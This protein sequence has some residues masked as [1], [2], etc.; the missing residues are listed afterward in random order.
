MAARTRSGAGGSW[1]ARATASRWAVPDGVHR[2]QPARGDRPLGHRHAR[3]PFFVLPVP[4]PS[5]TYRGGKPRRHHHRDGL[6]GHMLI[7]LI[8][9]LD[10]E[11]SVYRKRSRCAATASTTSASPAPTS[12]P[13]AHLPGARLPR[14]VP[15]RGADRGRGGLPRQRLPG[16]SSASR[17]PAGDPGMDATF[18]RFW[19]ASRRVGRQRS[20]PPLPLITDRNDR[21][22]PAP[23]RRRAPGN[24]SAGYQNAAW[25]SCS[26]SIFDRVLR[27]AG[28][29]RA[30]AAGEARLMLTDSDRP[31]RRRP[32]L[33]VGDR[34][35]LRRQARGTRSASAGPADLATLAFSAVLVPDRL[36][37][38]ASRC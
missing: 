22:R 34:G 32:R 11:P 6:A 10:G 24:N 1:Q 3:G 18:T 33:H 16:R 20:R 23:P 35:V 36:C 27:P 21:M 28:A 8:Q 5:Q 17:A 29:Q 30:D 13:T 25:C 19:E 7:E 15:R 38:H 26:A 14:G 4:R 2:P 37:D 9:P 31:D 12:T